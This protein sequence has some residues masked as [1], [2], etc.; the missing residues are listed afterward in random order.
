MPHRLL[1]GTCFFMAWT[2]AA[3]GQHPI[4]LEKLKEWDAAAPQPSQDQ[5]L[6]Q[7]KYA[8]AQI[9]PD[10]ARCQGT[11][12]QIAEVKPATAD[13]YIFNGV[14]NGTVRNGWFSIVNHPECDEAAVRYLTTQSADGSLRTVRVNRGL[15]YAHDSL[16]ADTLPLAAI[17]AAATLK[18]AG[19][20]CDFQSE[21]RLGVVRVANEDAGLGPDQYGVRYQGSWSE[22]WPVS[23]CDRTVEV[24]VRFKADG[25]GGAY[26]E[27]S[28]QLAKLLPQSNQ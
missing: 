7:I 22:A 19:I 13:R 6:A 18:R 20:E 3:A 12:G 4:I 27:M 16:I 28:G 2:T 5:F 8:E 24:L 15:S 11:S 21:V 1:V 25:D 26:T 14:V 23:I 9:Y 17:Q 10:S